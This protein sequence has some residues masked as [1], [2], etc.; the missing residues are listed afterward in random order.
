MEEI[1]TKLN[2]FIVDV[3]NIPAPYIALMW[4]LKIMAFTVLLAY[5]MHL[6][7][8]IMICILTFQLL[9]SS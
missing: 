6:V 4:L 8:V 3:T 1:G 7:D 9:M 2:L 5:S